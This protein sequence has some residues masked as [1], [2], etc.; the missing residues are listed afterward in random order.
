[1]TRQS[2][3]NKSDPRGK[4][5]PK[6]DTRLRSE[7]GQKNSNDSLQAYLE[8]IRRYP[9]LRRMEE[10]EVSWRYK[11]FGDRKTKNILITS[12]LRLV[13]KIVFDYQKY[14][15]FSSIDLIQEG[16]IGLMKAVEKYNPCK[17]AKFSYY[18]SFWI[19]AFILKYINDN[20]SVVKFASNANKKNL[21][22]QVKKEK[23]RL[24][25]M[26][27]DPNPE[28]VAENLDIKVKNVLDVENIFSRE[29]VS[30]DQPPSGDSNTPLIDF[31]ASDVN[32][33][34]VILRN[35]LK[36]KGLAIFNRLREKLSER[37]RH[38]FD[39]RIC[40][41]D[42]LTL[43]ELGEQLKT[44]RETIRQIEAKVFKKIKQFKAVEEDALA[45][46]K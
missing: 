4:T 22:R 40:C 35:D 13:V 26:D 25:N 30:F 42:E 11:V 27:I 14:G 43:Q 8:N 15:N 12:N 31:T 41:Q 9:L 7:E 38:V 16:N 5:G 28:N 29:D 44:S 37:E 18:A 39:N 6:K 46:L 32:T 45:K 3:K 19:K 34:K 23:Q 24:I 33:E 20:W 2:K 1:M 10:R 21:I 17:N 36:E